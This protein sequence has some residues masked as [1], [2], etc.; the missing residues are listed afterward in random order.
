MKTKGMNTKTKALGLLSIIAL[1]AVAG[2]IVSV[3]QSTV[4]ADDTIT[5]AD[6]IES[7]PITITQTETAPNGEQIASGIMHRF[8]MG[9]KGPGRGFGGCGFGAIEVSAEFTAKVTGIIEADSDVQALISEGY[10]VTMVRPYIKT[11]VDGDGNVVTKASTAEVVLN[12]TNGRVIVFVDIEEA[13]VT[14][15]VI[16]TVTEINK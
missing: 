10:N 4:Q 16:L 6:D 1:A 8:G 5:T 14:K 9:H 11:V 15:I 3:L 2:T 13:K 12:G 7:T